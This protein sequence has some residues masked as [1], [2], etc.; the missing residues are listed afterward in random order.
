MGRSASWERLLGKSSLHPEL[1]TQYLFPAALPSKR[2]VSQPAEPAVQSSSTY[3]SSP[4]KQQKNYYRTSVKLIITLWW[5]PSQ[6][7]RLHSPSLG[8]QRTT[9]L[10]CT[11]FC[12]PF[13]SFLSF[14]AIWFL[15]P[16]T[17]ASL[18]SF[19]FFIFLL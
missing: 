15:F 18:S 19:F 17:L 5:V 4:F 13:I 9:L 16:S 14:D 2:F 7:T 8:P 11:R 1:T 6:K 10:E 12:L 3:T